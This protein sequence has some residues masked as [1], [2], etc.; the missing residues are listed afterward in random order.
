MDERR[1]EGALLLRSF[2]ALCLVGGA[3]LLL[4]DRDGPASWTHLAIQWG[5]QSRYGF[6]ATISPTIGAPLVPPMNER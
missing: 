2:A 5:D 4:D 6:S 1:V 3:G